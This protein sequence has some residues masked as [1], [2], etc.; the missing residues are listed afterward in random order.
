MLS[1]KRKFGTI[2]SLVIFLAIIGALVY[3]IFVPRAV[4]VDASKV[5][6]GPF[7]ETIRSD[8]VLRAKERYTVPA[9]TDSDIRRV[10]L[11][12]GDVVK[13]GS[14]I[15]E[16]YWEFKW[17]P[18]VAPISGV[19]SKIHRESAGPIRRGDP[20]VE[21]VDPTQLEVI[22]ELLTTDAVRL[23]EDAE[24][25]IENWAGGDP[26]PAKVTRIS[27][28][29]FTKPSALGVEEERT[30]V[31]AEMMNPSQELIEK[32]GSNFHVDITFKV[33]ETKRALKV[34]AGA[35]FRDG[36]DWAVF[37]A[38]NGR[39][40]KTKVELSGLGSNEASI[41]SGLREGEIVLV[42]PGDLVKDGA[43]VEIKWFDQ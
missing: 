19:I 14:A 23:R 25:W 40:R 12:V 21:I 33:S 42:Y 6:I 36:S 30:E 1:L 17:I 34:P 29:G 37:I 16:I 26:I 28:A 41:Q 15:T 11:K 10:S 18:V 3:V 2:L 4:K 38:E 5:T 9:F 13:K 24:A 35:L 31:T 22:A 20:I 8:G 39:A 7:L 27:K 32:A 43:R